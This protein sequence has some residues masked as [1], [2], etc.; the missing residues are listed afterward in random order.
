MDMLM[1]LGTTIAY[2]SSIAMLAVDAGLPKD[3]TKSS[4]HGT[5]FDA[6]VFLTMFLMIGRLLEA[7][8][9]AKAGDAVSLLGKLRPTEAILV[10]TDS[11]GDVSSA[12][13]RTV[14]LDHLDF[15]DVVRV[16][17]G[18]PPPYDGRLVDGKSQ[19]D[20]SSLTGESKPL[21]KGPG[22]EVFSG[23]IN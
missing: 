20:E 22:D 21:F 15:G 23:T 9:K 1:S 14:S 16:A 13:S 18:A 11:S 6:V 19:F 5:F 10:Q 3:G 8:S 17:H 4:R 12:C 7:Y 2:F